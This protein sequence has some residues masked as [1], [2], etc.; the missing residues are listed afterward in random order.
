MSNEWEPLH[1]PTV[2]GFLSRPLLDAT[3]GHATTYAGFALIACLIA[4][5]SSAHMTEKPAM[6]KRHDARTLLFLTVE[7]FSQRHFQYG[8]VVSRRSNANRRSLSYC[9]SEGEVGKFPTLCPLGL[10][11][12]P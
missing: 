6:G 5:Q 8:L 10:R 3:H 7:V 2:S 4:T 11:Y 9:S 12:T 1:L